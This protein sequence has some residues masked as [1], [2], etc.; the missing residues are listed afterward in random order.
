MSGTHVTQFENDRAVVEVESF[1]GEW[2]VSRIRDAARTEGVR[3]I[4][5]V[6]HKHG[7]FEGRGC[8]W[9]LL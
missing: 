2:K 5:D 7:Q 6:G 1:I 9:L 4:Y 3:A 8:D